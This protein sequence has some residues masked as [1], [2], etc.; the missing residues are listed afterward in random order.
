[1]MVVAEVLQAVGDLRL[2]VDQVADDRARAPV[3]DPLGDLVEDRADVG[4]VP[5]GGIVEQFEDLAELRRPGAA[6]ATPGPRCRTAPGPRRRSG[7]A[8]GATAPRRGSCRIRACSDAPLLNVIEAEQSSR[9]VARRL[10]SSWNSLTWY[11]SVR[12]SSFQ[13][14]ARMS[15]PGEYARWSRYSTEN[16]WYGLRCRPVRNPSTT[17]RATS[18]MFPTRASPSGSKYL[19]ARSVQRITPG[20]PSFAVGLQRSAVS[21]QRS[22]VSGQRSAVQRSAVSG[23][24][25]AVSGQRSAVSG[26]RSAVSGQRSAVSGQRSAVS[27]Q[28]SAVSG[29]KLS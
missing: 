22:A 27:G 1:M 13:S 10:V 15:S 19:V 8:S 29:S 26:Q 11:L 5:G 6:G 7:G 12:A 24:R 3:L 14:S 16:P 25:S 28:R 2:I 21:G 17:C 18:S 9:I 4:V 20:V 23:Q